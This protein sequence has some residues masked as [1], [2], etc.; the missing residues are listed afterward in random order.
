MII[1]ETNNVYYETAAAFAT[2]VLLAGIYWNYYRLLMRHRQRMEALRNNT[3]SPSVP[4]DDADVEAAQRRLRLRRL[5]GDNVDFFMHGGP[6]LSEETIHNVL[7]QYT[8]ETEKPH[9][10]DGLIDLECGNLSGDEIEQSDCLGVD[11]RT[12]CAVCLTEFVDGDLLIELTCSHRYHRD[13]ITSWLMNRNLCP[14]CKQLAVQPAHLEAALASETGAANDAATSESRA[15]EDS[16]VRIS[17]IQQEEST[18]EQRRLP[19][20]NIGR[21]QRIPLRSFSYTATATAT[22]ATL[23]GRN[24]SA[25]AGNGPTINASNI[26][27]VA[28]APTSPESEHSLVQPFEYPANSVARTPGNRS[29]LVGQRALSV[30]DISDLQSLEGD[31]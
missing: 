10:I 23:F 29:A 28:P 17:N 2:M 19:S 4:I 27:S 7:Q 30:N 16:D 1:I 5:F 13:C 24:A 14:M 20:N 9:K 26:S 3:H 15:N 22:F 11:A 31:D 6:G 18:G 25:S 21:Q 12:E 8:Y